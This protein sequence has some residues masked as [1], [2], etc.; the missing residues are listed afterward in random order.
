[1]LYSFLHVAG[2]EAQ[3]LEIP[4]KD[5][6]QPIIHAFK[7]YCMGKANITVV[8]YQFNTFKQKKE[9]IETYIRELKQRIMY[10]NYGEMEKV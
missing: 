7:E 9:T 2:A 8:R 4:E 6:I 10:C 3:K 1:M 5:K